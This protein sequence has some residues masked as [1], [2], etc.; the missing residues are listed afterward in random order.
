MMIN[1]FGNNEFD[2]I[3]SCGADYFYKL[4]PELPLGAT[5]STSLSGL[6]LM[7]QSFNNIKIL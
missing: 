3:R 2:F 1:I 6:K 5:I 7:L 4:Y